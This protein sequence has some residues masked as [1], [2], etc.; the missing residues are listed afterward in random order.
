MAASIAIELKNGWEAKKKTSK[1]ISNPLIESIYDAAIQNGAKAGK[2]SGAGG[3][4][5][6]MFIVDP[7]M[8]LNVINA[9]SKFDGKVQS[10][11]F[12]DKGTKGWYV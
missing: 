5:F 9:L 7:L 2:I 11:E 3:G 6:M 12:V 1:V 4:G 8:K 10:V